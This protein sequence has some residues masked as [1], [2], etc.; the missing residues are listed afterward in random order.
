MLEYLEEN[1]WISLLVLNYLIAL[2]IIMFI[3][4]HNRNPTKTIAFIL[5]LVALPFIGILI[6]IFFGQEYR[7]TKFYKREEIYSHDRIK[8]WEK[9]FLLERD[10]LNGTDNPI[11]TKKS[12]IINLLQNNQKTPVTVNNKVKILWNGNN[13][14][15]SLFEDLKKAEDHIHLEYYIFNSDE[16]GTQLIDILCDKSREGVSVKVSYD[17][18]GSEMS[19]KGLKKMK[20]A[21][22]E[23]CSFQPVWFKNLHRKVNYRNHRKIV[24]IDGKVGY[25]GGINICDFYLNKE[26]SDFF[27]RD[28]HSRIEGEAVK[29]LQTQFLYTWNF[30][31]EE[32]IEVKDEYYPEVEIDANVAVQIAA[33]GPDTDYPNIMEAVLMAINTADKYI[34]IT[35][36]YFIPN[37]EILTALC[38]ASRS[39]VEVK[40][41][42]PRK[43]D[44]WVARHATNSF[45]EQ[46]LESGVEIFHYEKGM[47]HAKTMVIDDCFATVGTCNMDHRSFL[48]NFE[49]N[50]LIYDEGIAAEMLKQY[51]ADLEEC[52]PNSLEQW[53][54]R[55]PFRK[56]K[57]SFWRLWAPLL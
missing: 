31:T 22:V 38:T 17:Y 28:T 50:A 7:K 39:G 9:K 24:V 19:N 52:S 20:E 2:G 35:T 15:K 51:L 26:D 27:W 21:G 6:Y 34:Y 44:S 8:K 57:E 46:V 14:F 36:P 56:I 32:E 29:A 47:V 3:V 42:I 54:H 49:I 55:S 13:K 25:V 12:K 43:G 41:I 30:L 40:I 18:L 23:V 5:A 45:V 48:L 16:I 1:I 33:S 37:E 10:K 53:R 4:M 11:F